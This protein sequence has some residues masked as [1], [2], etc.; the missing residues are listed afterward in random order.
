MTDGMA[1]NVLYER[2]ILFWA[3][4]DAA[5]RAASNGKRNLD[6]VMIP[7]VVRARTLGGEGDIGNQAKPGG[8]PGWFTPDELVDSLAKVGGPGVRAEF[9]SVIVQ[10]K[11]IVPR[12]T[13]FGPCFEL[14]A[15]RLP[16]RYLGSAAARADTVR[17]AGVPLT[18]AFL[19]YRAPAVPDDACRHW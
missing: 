6:S 9:D 14:R 19:W 7:L 5:I 3:D 1:Q 4:V 12:A 10:G 8:Q 18:D 2:G 11:R 17:G 16:D 13:A 15:T